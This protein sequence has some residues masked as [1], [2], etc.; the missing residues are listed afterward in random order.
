MRKVLYAPVLLLVAAAAVSPAAEERVD[1]EISWKIRQEATANSKILQT[2]HMLTDVYGPRLTGSPNLKAAGEWAVEQM[3]AWGLQNGHL[4]PWDFGRVGWTNERLTAHIVSPVKDALV[5]EV[6][7]WT[8]GTSGVV[9]APAVQLALPPRP[10]RDV[11]A[12]HLDEFKDTVR[13]RIVLVGTPQQ[14]LVAFNPPALRRDDA[15]V[16]AQL[17]APPAQGPQ[18]Q[19]QLQQAQQQTGG[20]PPPLTNNQ[21]Q[22]Q[23]N[24][25]LLANGALVRINDAGRD[26]G[27]IRAFQNGTY[28]V[29][30]APPTLVMRNEDYGRIWRLLGDGRAVELEFDIVNRTYPEGR[31]SNNVVAEIPGTDKADEVVM[32]GGHL[33][34]WHAATGATDN[35]V[36]CAVTME[37]A[38][39]L[40]AIGVKPRRTIRLA[41]WSGEEQGLLGSQAYVREHFG[42]FEQPKPEYAKFAG[43][44]NIDTGTGRARGLTVFGPPA[45]GDVLRD[46][47]APLKDLGILGAMT[48]RSRQR[49]GTD[50]TSFNEAGLPGINVLQ[51]PIQYQS[52][53]WHTNLDTY[54]RIV[55]DDVKKSAIAIAAAV[56]HL[57]MRDEPLPR[58]A[59][60]EMPPPRLQQQPAPQPQ[61]PPAAQTGSGQ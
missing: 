52:Y 39:I 3:Q 42:T 58:F 60:G 27:Q 33:D 51:D 16:L 4:E 18:Q 30:K 10:T 32:L 26:H 24:Q 31:T 21:M 41:L 35:A 13:G 36:G 45:A 5:A 43:Y 34:S 25:F 7:A 9:R 17:N 47:V 44:L 57:A 49:G 8:P 61:A 40:A 12:T 37:A 46:A 29:A 23:L 56:Y 2:L 55:E 15:D 19:P 11:L 20:Q 38:R 28:D 50:S 59:A 14:V 22:E 1:S 48:T 6:L 54:E 53:S